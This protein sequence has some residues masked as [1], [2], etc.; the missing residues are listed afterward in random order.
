[1]TR[2]RNAECC[3]QIDKAVS[4]HIPN[5]GSQCTLNKNRGHRFDAGNV[6]IFYR[7]EP[8]GQGEGPG[9][10]DARSQLGELITQCCGFVFTHARETVAIFTGP[11]GC[12]RQISASLPGELGYK[13]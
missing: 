9:S 7:A 3:A 11:V 13:V 2:R 8:L 5:I 10:R 4:I 6:G 1:M 12:E